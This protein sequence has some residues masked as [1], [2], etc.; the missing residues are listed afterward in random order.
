MQK[1]WIFLVVAMA[2]GAWGIT[3][4]LTYYQEWF[5]NYGSCALNRATRNHFYVAALSRSQMKLPPGMT[6]PNNHPLCKPNRCIKVTGSRGTVVLKISDTCWACAKDDVDVAHTVY[7]MLEDPIR[8]RVK[9]SWKFV[10][11]KTNP[12][13]RY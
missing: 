8:G 9:V 2:S 3:G 4:D 5:G 11:C 12:P 7:P 13:G 1:L 6:N 10:N